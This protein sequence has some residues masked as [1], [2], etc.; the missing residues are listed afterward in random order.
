MID[1]AFRALKAVADVI[2]YKGADL[3]CP[4]HDKKKWRYKGLPKDGFHVFC[5]SH[6]ARLNNG[7]TRY[8]VSNIDRELIKLRVETLAAI[9]DI[10][11][12]LQQSTLTA[13]KS[14][15]SAIA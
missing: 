1:D 2:M 10:Y 11:C 6:T 12:G 14:S 3:A 8:G 4:I 9:E 15:V 7:L 13:N 5:E